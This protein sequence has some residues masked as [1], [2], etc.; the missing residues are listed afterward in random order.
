M[1]TVVENS[2]VNETLK[3]LWELES[4]GIAEI[5]NPVMSQEEER[6]VAD[7]NRGLNFD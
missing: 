1:L 6:A 7:F 5:K 4:I 2:G 3:I